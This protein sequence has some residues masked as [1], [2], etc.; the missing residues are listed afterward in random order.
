MVVS[1]DAMC[2]EK[3]GVAYFV[4]VVVMETGDAMAMSVSN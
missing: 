4:W 1:Y 3:I 2:M